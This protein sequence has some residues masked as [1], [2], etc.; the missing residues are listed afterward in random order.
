MT[1]YRFIIVKRIG[2]DL[3][4]EGG[5][6]HYWGNSYGPDISLLSHKW[7]LWGAVNVGYVFK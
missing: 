1:A 7:L 2:I 4:I 5:P 3:S 6:N